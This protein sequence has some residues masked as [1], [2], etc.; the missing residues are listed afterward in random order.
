[1][2]GQCCAAMGRYTAFEMKTAAENFL[3]AIN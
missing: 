3:I 1:M 2:Y